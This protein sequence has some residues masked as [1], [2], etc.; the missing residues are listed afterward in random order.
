MGLNVLIGAVKKFDIGTG[1]PYGITPNTVKNPYAKYEYL[2]GGKGC[3]T[4][5]DP[6]LEA[7]CSYLVSE[8]LKAAGYNIPAF[9]THDL[10]EGDTLKNRGQ[11]FN[12]H[13]LE[14]TFK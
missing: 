14:Y 3:N 12:L 8:A 6:F 7:D 1:S 9:G 11:V 10:F 2:L 4:D 5:Y 13:F